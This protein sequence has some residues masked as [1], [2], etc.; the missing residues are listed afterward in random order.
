MSS[1]VAS[2]RRILLGQYLTSIVNS[3]TTYD[4]PDQDLIF[5]FL[6]AYDHI[7]ND[8]SD[9]RHPSTQ[10]QPWDSRHQ[11]GIMTTTLRSIDQSP[12]P[13]TTE[14]VGDVVVSDSVVA[15]SMNWSNAPIAAV[16]LSAWVVMLSL[17]GQMMKTAT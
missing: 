1:E 2:S 12:T 5:K 8:I 17:M 3:C 13:T 14:G 11:E 6:G 15:Q 4:T 16:L 7:I 9:G 10:Q